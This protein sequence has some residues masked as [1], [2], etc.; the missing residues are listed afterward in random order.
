MMNIDFS[1]RL[2][3]LELGTFWKLKA[4]VNGYQYHLGDTLSTQVAAGRCFKVLHVGD[5]EAD[6]SKTFLRIKVLLL[7]DGYKCWLSVLDLLGNVLPTKP[8]SPIL[9]SRDQIKQYLPE[10]LNWVENS[11]KRS[12]KYLW[13]G[14]IG[15]DFD[16]SGLVQTAF[17]HKGIWLPRDAYQQEQFC[18]K[19]EICLDNTSDLQSGDL[20][21]FGTKEKC[22]HVAIYIGKGFYWH[23]SGS[24]NGLNGIG[25]NRI[26]GKDYVSSYYRALFRSAGRVMSCHDGS[27]LN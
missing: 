17:S 18:K 7:E 21:F 15:P 20:L 5:L 16:C 2:N 12:N 10:V 9:F 27:E 11:S 19:I 22:T 26:N 25:V 1:L 6:I 8:V 3:S 4:P 24:Q 13:G 23:S 14:T